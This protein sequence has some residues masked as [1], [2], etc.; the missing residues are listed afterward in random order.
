MTLRTVDL[1]L[2]RRTVG[3]VL[4][5][6]ARRN[7]ERTA[8]LFEDRRYSY[9]EMDRLTDRLANGLL[10][11][12]IAKGTHVALLMDNKPEILFLCYALG[13]A[14]AVTVPVNTA[15]K[16][17][18]LAY[19]LTQSSCTAIVLD[20]PLLERFLAVAP[21][22][23]AIG[24]TIVLDEA[25]P[26]DA[27][28]LP[29]GLDYRAL[30]AGPEGPPPVDVRP[31]DLAYLMYT[32]GTTGPSKGNMMPHAEAITIGHNYVESFG[33]RPDDTI[34]TSLPLFHGNALMCSAYPALVADATLAISRRFS[35]RAH[36]EE[37]R[38][39]GATQFNLLGAM[40]N[41]LWSRPPGPEDRE[42][43]A[44]QCMI[45]PVPAFGHEFEARFGLKL[46]SVYALTDFGNLTMLPPDH[47]P[48]KWR[49]AGQAMPDVTLA[50]LDDDDMPLPAGEVGEI[51]ARNEAPWIATVG[52]WN[53]PEATAASRRNLWVHTGDRG[54]LDE[55][56]YLYF[57]DRKKD[58]I[59]RRG[60]NISSF[61]V[62][63]II[64]RHGAV[65]DV[66]AYAVRSEMSEDEVMVSV[67]LRAG[68]S[69]EPADLIAHCQAN[70]AYFMVPR[71]VEF[72]ADLPRTMTEKVEKYKLQA[73]AAEGLATVWDREKAG[74]VV[75]R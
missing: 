52:Y 50:I 55:E 29:G 14:G 11:A 45:V 47:P 23:P 63:Q 15:A 7:G 53:M 13:K 65:E 57:V 24:R 35:A 48:A 6:A 74:I 9:A 44:R 62:E 42:H 61:E 25:G 8:V 16:G 73:R 64:L 37:V 69:L 49:S 18:L 2:A 43:K 26:F 20:R 36:W 10:A 3:Q 40:A 58:A 31:W 51:C 4:A 5:D 28:D 39:F 21:Q 70:M 32:S 72:V 17:E 68:A 46:T 27:S 67:V 12:G 66:A 56:G 59:R 41:I 34:Y 1:P 22:C 60:E 19:Y 75:R 38:R 33:Y 30:E 54:Y 71:Y